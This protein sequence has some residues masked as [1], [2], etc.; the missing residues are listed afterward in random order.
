MLQFWEGSYLSR[1]KQSFYDWGVIAK[2]FEAMR[3]MGELQDTMKPLP[4]IDGQMSLMLDY[5]AE[6]TKP[7]AF[8]FSQEIIDAVLTRGSGVSEGKFRIY[9]QFQ[10]SLSKKENVDF[11]KN[12][13]GW[14]GSYPVIT[15]TG[16]DE[17]HDGKGIKIS[18][19]VNGEEVKVLLNWNQVE[20]RISELI[21][22]DRYLNPKEKEL[23][24][25][26]LEQHEIRRAEAAE[27]HKKR[28]ILSTAP[29]EKEFGETIPYS[30]EPEYRLLSRLKSD[31]EY[32]LGEGARAEKHLWTGS[33]EKQIEKM[34]E[35]Y[36]QLPEKPEWLSKQ[37][38]DNYERQMTEATPDQNKDRY[39]Y[40]LGNTV[41]I[42]ANEYE[43]LSFDNERVMLYDTQ[44]P[45]FNKEMSRAEFD[46]KVQENP[47]NDH[48][49]VKDI[50]SEEITDNTKVR[51]SLDSGNDLVHWIYFNPDANAGGQYVSGD[52][53]FSVFEE[54]I[55]QYDIANHPENTDRFVADLEEMSDQ[56]LADI[57][58]PFFME[59]ENDYEMDCDYTRFTP[60]NILKIHKDIQQFETEHQAELNRM[61]GQNEP[62]ALPVYD[63]IREP[64]RGYL[65]VKSENPDSLVLYQVG[66]FYEAYGEDAQK[67]A[68]ALDLV[69]TSRA[70]SDSE[71]IPMVGFPQHA[72]ETYMNMLID[73]GFD[74]AVST[75]D[76]SER[77]VL[78]I[79]STNKEDPVQSKPIGRIDYIHTDGRVRES[80]EYTSPYQFEK[81]IKEENYYGVPMKIVL[82]KDRDG[83]T[84]PQGVISQLDPPPQGV[85]IIDSPYLKSSLDIAKEI[86]DEYCR[87]EFE[88]DEGA[89]YSNLSEVNVAYTTTED[90]KHEIQA[91]V[92]LVD[93][94]I[95]TLVDGTVIRT[96]Q[97]DSL[98]DMTERG[99][100][101]LSFD[102]LVF[103][104]EEE[105]ERVEK[106]SAPVVPAWE[107]PKKNKVQT[108]DLHPEIPM[109][110]RHNFDLANNEITEVNKKERFHRNYA[111]ITVL[112]RCQEENRFATPDEQK[113][114][115]RYVGWGGIPEAFDERAGAWHTEY[116]M[117]KNI[118]PPE[119]YESARESTL[120]AFYTPPTV[121]KAVYKAMEQLG[122]REGNILE[123]SCGIGHFIGM[124][125]DSMQE[126]KVYGVE[127]D[128]VSAGI[129]QQLYQ[130]TSIAA[131]GFEEANLPDSF[132]DAVVGNV[133]FGDFKVPDK[134][135]DKHKFLIHDYFFA[136]SLDKL[137]PGGVMALITS[138]GT[139]DKENPAVRKYIAQRADLLGAIR[140]PNN[141][142]K[143]NAGTEV[144]S[145]ILI[146]QK[147][148]R[149]VDIEPDW[150]HL[151]TDANGITMN[152]YFVEHPEMI[153]GEMKM[154]SGRFGPEPSCVPYEGADL[155]EQLSE[156]VANI[157]GEITAYEVEDELTEEDN[158]I[159]A[160][161]TV[162]NFSYTL[163]D[164][165]I[166]FR[167]N[168]RMA[169]VDV[170]ATAENR[171]KGMIAIRDCVRN[172]IE[173]QTE[174]YPD[175]AIK[176][177]QSKLNSLYDTFTAKYGLINSRANSSAFSQDSSFSLLS[178]LEVLGDDGTLE[179]KADMFFKRTIKPHT[180]VTSVDT[181][182]EAL[183]VSMGEKACIDMEYM[184]QLSGKTEEEI[185]ADLKG[186][187]FLNPMYGYGSSTEAKY[188]MA[189]EYLSG[190]VREKLVWA[191]KS[192]QLSPEEYS[193][194]VEALQKVQPKDLT[195]S[196]ISV[197]LGATWLP[198]EIVEQF[199][200]E[201][202][203]TPRYAQ[204]NIK[205]HFSEYTGEW[206]IEG[207]SYDRGNV[208][209][210]STY[211]T[212]RINAY[213]IIE[214]TLNLKDVRIFDY[215]EDADGKKKAILNKKE[216]AIAQAKQ[217]LIKQGFQDWIW[218]DPERRERLCK[219][220]NEKFNSIRP[221]EYDGSHITFNGM[222]PEIE[223][224][225]HQRNAVAH[226]LYGGNTLLAHA[227]GAGKTFEMTAAAM[228]SKRLGLCSKSLFV[229]PNHL[230][231]QWASEFL[232]LYP[233]ANI[234]VATKKDFETKNR[235]R[236][237]GRIA[238]GDYDAI[239]IGHSQFEKI[240]MSIERQ[241]AILEQQLEEVTNG[242]ADLKRNRGDNFSVKQLERTK[243]SVK[244]KLDKLN[245][246]SKKDNVVTFEELGVDR[247]FIDE[248]HYY[249]NLFLYTKMRNVGGIAQ[250]EAQKSSD[251]FMKCR[252]LDEITGGRG[253]VFATGT[254]ISNS[255]VELYTIQRYLQYNT[256]VKNNLQH[257]DAWASTF[258]ETVT[259]VELT[260]EGTGYRAKTRFARFYNLPELMAMFKEVADI[261]TA[262]ML[263][264]PVPKAVY[265][266]I[267]VKPSEIQKQMV[268]E[269]AERAEKVRNGM[270]DASVD[271][272]LKITND[273]RKLAL[274]QRLINPMLP[275]FE[276]SKLN[277]CV[278]AM[279]ETWEKGK[280][281]RLTQL[282]FCDLSTPKNDGNFS[283][284][285]DIRKK[286]IERGVPAEEIKFIHEA[287]TEAKKLE[288]FKK[289]RRGDVRILMGSTAK[290][291]AGTNVQNKLAAS[292]DLD[293]PW[294]PS[295]LEQRLGR[296][297]RQ[298]NENPTVDIYRFVTEETFDA[299]LYQ[300]VEGKQ[301]FASQIMT[302]KSPVR[303]C[304][305]IDETAL[306]YA[307]IKMLATGNPYI[308]EKMDLDIQVQ[309]LRLLKSNFLSEKYALE[310]KIIKF[311][312]QEIARRTDTIEG[313]KSDIER[314]K[315]HP[316]PLD[317]NFI[318]MTVKGVFY[319]EKADAGNA[320]LNACQAMTSPDPVPLGEYRGFQTELSFD[321]FEKE[322]KVKLKGELGYSVSLGTDTFG[323]ITRLDNALE[324]LPKR[325]EMNEQELE[326]VKTQYETAKVDVEKPFNQEEEL[327][328]KTARL[329]E[330]NALLNVDKRENEIVGGEPDEGD[331]EPTP[332]S[333]D[334]ER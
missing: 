224:R 320:I 199:V 4:S 297:I 56:F 214:E 282:F 319:S 21:K 34:R 130:K 327:K 307:E 329:N 140:L 250:T 173:L 65:A 120:T 220:Y 244:Q 184:C 75:V 227:V 202:L 42:G 243:K 49:K 302:S 77:K 122:F 16:I 136:K 275:D 46:Q 145:D 186:V 89:E 272:M 331:E 293:C 245:D 12:E 299:Y 178:A 76:G 90:D 164:G 58:T 94:R 292:S 159:P 314:A 283:V 266:N 10:K 91:N 15:G 169:P 239:I 181:S 93:F 273:G 305:D 105:L 97:Y 240:P 23:Y 9:E 274:D 290:M 217:E 161:P 304:E 234:L 117:L 19:N 213:K 127:L 258:G 115:S 168:S 230:T 247:L 119:E 207:K 61:A 285:D 88:R 142:F 177:E 235:K 303:S 121:I 110:E 153:L 312:P 22:M 249:K 24:P 237:C 174:D 267:S 45:L 133:P 53:S 8:S 201:F 216:T 66:D 83:T 209:A 194:N 308:K 252:Y 322:Y 154:V 85:E 152:S 36:D 306:S 246:Q 57:N 81:D 2:H 111:A 141:T 310:D 84:I 163:V 315:Q 284:Y 294:R 165:K 242:I 170:S 262:D 150:V 180:P 132:F 69:M 264:L 79:V 291:G 271:N 318:G 190:N 238:T 192:A 18:K 14:G 20:K 143:G 179:K 149:I 112:K 63:R 25:A 128:T 210:Y 205:I 30:F 255:M 328:T 126:S 147:R 183:A 296:S 33:V 51:I 48:L 80:I 324:G 193:I 50:P 167:E 103:L 295:D 41:Y 7:S 52:L 40:H 131:Q 1:T 151:G 148:D 5:E 108:F 276:G 156:A 59:A 278:D 54:L 166:Y 334:R 268:A 203:G 123:P 31:C 114:L 86:I 6:V 325:L 196:E 236:F 26:W 197:R 162:R 39:E 100:K 269:L 289:V 28:E 32:F 311:Y 301:K 27:E 67:I 99:L 13:Y 176:E 138:K 64:Y 200:F 256:L 232:Q 300:L 78:S 70:I 62:N 281:K 35:L 233:S 92:N 259:A 74:L 144:V 44:F 17:M 313:L 134:R 208:K 47:M 38:I 222:N 98:E 241:R 279:F 129:A 157:H 260:P 251:L 172:L 3:L 95:E 215:E 198:P 195:A 330:L 139:M 206:N 68:E 188:L 211:G 124:L 254:P 298:G 257:F 277:A 286:L 185:F 265:H 96:E 219:L 113:I 82:Y 187:I 160:D 248:S 175:S 182:S 158:S 309:K 118:L 116:A 101:N 189:D 332:K 191:K 223:L 55:E 109:P 326:N 270:V 323:N 229:V 316:K 107:Q 29:P 60:E 87:E 43:I 11:L 125:P 228:E 212:S 135:Y 218:S 104:S 288:L 225:E 317:D 321:T 221:R 73:R 102:D 280:E 263:D 261:K 137:R 171:I 72:L 253:T 287:D 37:D 155:A 146:L 226:I 106:A 231:E 204:W 333:K 71:R